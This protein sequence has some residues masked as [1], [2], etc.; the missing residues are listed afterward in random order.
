MSMT[1]VLID[2]ELSK[3]Y[4]EIHPNIHNKIHADGLSEEDNNRAL[5]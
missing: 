1:L 4:A 3:I 5:Q 2:K